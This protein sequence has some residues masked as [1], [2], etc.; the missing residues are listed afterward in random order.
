VF[1]LLC[2]CIQTT[3]SKNLTPVEPQTPNVTP[4]LPADFTV[5]I[6]QEGV[7]NNV[8]NTFTRNYSEIVANHYAEI[9]N[10][11]AQYNSYTCGYDETANYSRVS[12][13]AFNDPRV[14]G[15]LRDGAIVKGIFMY[16]TWGHTKESYVDD[17]CSRDYVTMEFQYKGEPFEV[18]LNETTRRVIF[19]N[20]SLQFINTP[21]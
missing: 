14:Q 19:P 16:W 5:T 6:S 21:R 7:A 10:L 4:S 18:I 12:E 2:G 9:P 13:V 8:T 11:L 1:I 15:I 20:D 3:S 17:P